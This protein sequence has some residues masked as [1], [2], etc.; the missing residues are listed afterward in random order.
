MTWQPINKDEVVGQIAV[1]VHTGLRKGTDAPDAGDLWSA[2]SNSDTYAWLDAV[3]F[4][5]DGLYS[6]GYRVCQD[7]GN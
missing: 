2:I 6:M 4:C 7:D 3:T 1:G 5:V